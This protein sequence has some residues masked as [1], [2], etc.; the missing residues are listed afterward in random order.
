MNIINKQLIL[1]IHPD[2]QFKT[3]GLPALI[4]INVSPSTQIVNPTTNAINNN[5]NVPTILHFHKST[6]SPPLTPIN[7]V[8]T[9]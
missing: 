7:D 2:F 1:I 4:G 6:I 3:N 8:I 5:N 9:R